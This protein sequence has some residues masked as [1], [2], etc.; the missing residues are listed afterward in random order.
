MQNVPEPRYESPNYSNYQPEQ[1][2]LRLRKRLNDLL[3]LGAATPETFQQTI[4]QIFAEAE[5]QRQA[6]MTAAE[7][8]LRKYHQYNSQAAAFSMFSSISYSVINGYVVL[9]EKR[10]AEMAARAQEKAA[11]EA[12]AKADAA[13]QA[14]GAGPELS[15]EPDEPG[16]NSPP[17]DV[18][19]PA[20]PPKGPG[21]RKK[22]IG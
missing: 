19:A 2:Q 18:V 7:E 21:R 1:E 20:A 13:A 16:E 15:L 14:N 3:K 22:P 10:A 11:A 6:C 5:R 9:E 17:T 4:L 8:H 12:E